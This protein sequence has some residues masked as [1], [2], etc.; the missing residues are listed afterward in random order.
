MESLQLDARLQVDYSVFSARSAPSPLESPE[1]PAADGPQT[2]PGNDTRADDDGENEDLDPSLS[3]G[4]LS[5]RRL[6]LE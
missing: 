4:Q 2:K 3:P 5:S 1:E 6:V